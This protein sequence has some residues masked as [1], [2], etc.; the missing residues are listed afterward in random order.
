MPERGQRAGHGR[1]ASGRAASSISCSRPF[2]SARRARRPGRPALDCVRDGLPTS[3]FDRQVGRGS[4]ETC[5]E[6]RDS[7]RGAVRARPGDHHRLHHPHRRQRRPDR[8]VGLR[9]LRRRRDHQ[10]HRRGRGRRDPGRRSRVGCERG[11]RRSR[12][13]RR[14]AVA[15]RRGGRR[16]VRG[17]RQRPG[18]RH[19]ERQC[20]RGGRR[21]HGRSGHGGRR[22]A[23][24]Q[25]RARAVRGQHAFEPAGLRRL[26]AT[27]RR[28]AR[29][30]RGSR[31]GTADRPRAP[32][33]AGGSC[34]TDPWRPRC[35]R[36]R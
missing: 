27:R 4:K 9:L 22:C 31:R 24:A 1:P 19:R 26:G 18:R 35:R 34:S 21:G 20:P 30:C 10:P 33:S 2:C 3:A 8:H 13:G 6:T 17:R 36:A 28:G 7:G 25:R 5:D 16:S 11:R 15:G 29:R 14:R 12:R 23:V 32:A